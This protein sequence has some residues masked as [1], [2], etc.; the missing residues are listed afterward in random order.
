MFEIT[1]DT[2]VEGDERFGPVYAG[3]PNYDFFIVHCPKDCNKVGST[4]VKKK[5]ILGIKLRYPPRIILN[6]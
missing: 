5:F 2:K 6:M 1:C 3:K 4:A